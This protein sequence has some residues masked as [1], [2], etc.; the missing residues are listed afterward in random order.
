MEIRPART[1]DIEAIQTVARRSWEAAYRDVL[2]EDTVARTVAEWYSETSL[3]G[4]F[5]TPGTA[6]LV[7]V[8]EGER[9]ADP[10]AGGDGGGEHGDERGRDDSAGRA[11]G[12]VVGF[13]HGVVQEDEGDILRLYVDPDHWGEGI[14][15]A[16]YERLRD[17]LLDFNMKR[18][19]AN[20]LA[21]NDLGASFYEGLGFEPTGEATVTMG[22]EEHPERTYTREFEG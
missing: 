21:E 22:G 6:F 19:R 3:R 9:A 8:A 15:T 18:I 2:G 1:D 4:A 13:C 16:L 11:E 17:D 5:D 7:A 14:G 10:A 12:D 20:V